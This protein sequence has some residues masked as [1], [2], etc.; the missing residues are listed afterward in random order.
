VND[1]PRHQKIDDTHEQTLGVWLHGQR[2]DYR[3]GRLA[4]AKEKQLNEILPAWREGRGH[5][6]G[7]RRSYVDDTN[8][9]PT[10]FSA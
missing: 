9:P 7:G 2:I 4:P 1:W 6:G 3:A 5:R 8:P 10:D